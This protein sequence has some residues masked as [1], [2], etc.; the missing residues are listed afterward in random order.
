M[1]F[2]INGTGS[3][4]YPYVGK[5]YLYPYLTPYTNINSR[6]TADLN[7]TVKTIKHLEKNRMPSLSC[8]NK[9]DFLNKTHKMFIIK[10]NI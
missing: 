2:S 5:M 7:M 6:W 1:F 4:E 3:I 9:K 8:W 10:E